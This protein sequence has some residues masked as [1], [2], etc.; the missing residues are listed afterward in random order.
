MLGVGGNSLEKHT[1]CQDMKPFFPFILFVFVYLVFSLHKQ[2]SSEKYS[3]SNIY[4][5][6]YKH[7][8][9]KYNTQKVIQKAMLIQVLHYNCIIIA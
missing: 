1:S 6:I 9:N 8:N 3:Y 5:N 7:D 2:S 4:T